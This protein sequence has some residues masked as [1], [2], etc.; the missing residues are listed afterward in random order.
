[1]IK[2]NTQISK[3][4]DDDTGERKQ[5]REWRTVIWMTMTTPE[6]RKGLN[7]LVSGEELPTRDHQ[8]QGPWG[9]TYMPGIVKKHQ[10]KTKWLEQSERRAE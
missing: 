8:I 3:T 1:M 4:D 6:R 2:T 7:Q 9:V 10:R 5:S